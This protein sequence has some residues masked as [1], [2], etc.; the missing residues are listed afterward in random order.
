MVSVE[1][2]VLGA[3]GVQWEPPFV[4]IGEL[5]TKSGVYMGGGLKDICIYSITFTLSKKGN[6]F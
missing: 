5:D 4:G 1:A 6:S 2:W 3:G